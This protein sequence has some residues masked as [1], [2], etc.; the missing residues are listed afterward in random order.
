MSSEQV[1]E[2]IRM[3]GDLRSDNEQR[4]NEMIAKQNLTNGNVKANTEFRLTN[5]QL[6]IDLKAM[7]S[8][9]QMAKGGFNT[10]K[11]ILGF[12]GA[13]NLLILAKLFLN[14]KL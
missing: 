1:Q 10:I 4:H 3:I 6:I 7:L 9:W 13:S 8:E 12:L 14:I 11:W 2:I 5:T